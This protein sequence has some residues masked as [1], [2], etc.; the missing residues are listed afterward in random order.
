[1]MQEYLLTAELEDSLK[2]SRELGLIEAALIFTGNDDSIIATGVNKS[3]Y[4]RTFLEKEIS[5]L[6]PP[7]YLRESTA[8]HAD[9]L[10]SAN[11]ALKKGFLTQG[12]R[13]KIDTPVEWM[14]TTNFSR[15]VRYKMQ[16]WLVM[17]APLSAYSISSDENFLIPCIDHVKDWVETFI[18]NNGYDEFSW[19]DMAVG[20]RASKLAYV[21]RLA[22][23]RREDI[24]DIAGLIVAAEIHMRE[25]MQEDKIAVHS[26]HGLF[27]MSGL[28]ALGKSLPFLTLAEEA[29]KFAS[30]MIRNMLTQH[31]TVDFLHKEH[32]P[33]Y[34]IFMT[35]YVSILLDSKFMSDV[36]EFNLLAK[37]TI[38]SAKWFAQPD[39]V[40]LPFGDT[41][42]IPIADRAH[43][44]LNKYRNRAVAPSGLKYFKHGGLVIHSH[45]SPNKG[46]VGYL[47]VNG[48]F[49]SRQHK[50]ADDFNIQLFHDKVGI[51]TD[52]G[53]Y[54]YQYDLPERIYIESTRA[55]NCVEIDGH[56]YSRF[57][58]DSCA[59]SIDNVIEIGEC[60]FIDAS[61]KRTRLIPSD[62]S[63]NNIKSENAI[64]CNILHRR[65][66]IYHPEN[67]LLVVDHMKSKEK[68]N[69][70]Q[71]FNLYPE[72]D[73]SI[74]DSKCL[75]S[76]DSGKAIAT[77]ENIYPNDSEVKVY[78][79]IEKPRLQGWICRNGHSLER[80]NSIGISSQ[81]DST[82]IATVINLNTVGN[83]KYYF[84][85]GTDGKYLRFVLKRDESKYE[86]IYRMKADATE[87]SYN[88]NGIL[89]E[90]KLG[91]DD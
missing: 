33:M 37:E 25:L 2:L 74:M 72:L 47:A 40:I 64:P 46:P 75:F 14:K 11:K 48:S 81:G 8:F 73:V 58:S 82:V 60:L 90:S 70:T 55:H 27:Q 59:N 20:Q 54:T 85:E 31:F 50:H 36:E 17:D 56:N 5:K 84:K 77:L 43:F 9:L 34:H 10:K 78:N 76:I 62:L 32:S 61:V 26:N 18:C 52:A 87:I 15:N 83:S 42:A 91:I 35:N 67:F 80:T 69:Y 23:E 28:L 79:G 44:A 19:Y 65:M 24:E 41:P 45:Y 57:L 63:N 30:E 22:I 6:S 68:H 16:A 7:F 89:N 88:A 21:L 13:I 1:M 3:D 66:V 86:F 4:L 12:I 38:E 29:I 39:G 49:H 53:T 51:L 71:W